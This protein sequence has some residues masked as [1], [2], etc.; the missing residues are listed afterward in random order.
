VSSQEMAVILYKVSL[1][2]RKA[3][4]KQLKRAEQLPIGQKWAG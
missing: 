2:P 1:W 4:H 3:T